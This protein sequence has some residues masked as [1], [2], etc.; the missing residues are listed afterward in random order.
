MKGW[1]YRVTV[2]S[3]RLKTDLLPLSTSI[4]LS[5]FCYD[6]HLLLEASICTRLDVFSLC[7]VLS[8]IVY[9]ACYSVYHVKLKTPSMGFIYQ[10]FILQKNWVIDAA[11]KNV[12]R[13]VELSKS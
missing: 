4:L 10:K 5:S 9:I 7:Y 8:M 1:D 2:G 3:L 6:H 13:A 12:E 11:A